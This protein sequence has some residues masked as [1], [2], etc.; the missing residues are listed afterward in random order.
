[1]TKLRNTIGFAF[2]ALSLLTGAVSTAHA[3]GICQVHPAL[4]DFDPIF[5]P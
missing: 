2:I 5:E 1:M 3:A 4:C